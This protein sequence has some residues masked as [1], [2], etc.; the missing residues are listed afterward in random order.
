MKRFSIA[1]LC[2]LLA[3][4]L[5]LKAQQVSDIRFEQ[6][7]KQIHIYYDLQGDETYNV[8]VFCS[9]DDGQTWG[10][11]L[12]KVAGAV[13]ENQQPGNNKE[14][15]WDVLVEREKL[16]GVII[17]KIEA[18]P[19]IRSFTDTRDG[20]TY[21]IITIGNQTWFAE[22]LNYE[23]SN[24]WCYANN[25]SFGAVYGRL[26]TW[27]A[28]MNA[29]PPGWHLPTDEEW[30]NLE[31]Y[32]GMSRSEAD[33]AGKRGM[34]EGDKLKSTNGWYNSG[35]GIDKISFSALPGGYRHI[36]GNFY[37][38]RNYGYW[39]SSTAYGNTYAWR[40]LLYYR[41]GKVFRGNRKKGTGFSVRC[42]RDY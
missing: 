16:T 22:N 40:R 25:S 38:L 34:D 12:Q 35:N 42:V 21:K 19:A 14:I 15:V 2:L 5:L 39:W 31:I 17:F 3:A 7:G 23:T 6:A 32:L 18:S 20:Q 11:S 8:E 29:C 36:D 13:G 9:M 10:Q 30:K 37:Y 28:A 24:S 26:Y 4:P 27:N 41:N 1:T 33:A